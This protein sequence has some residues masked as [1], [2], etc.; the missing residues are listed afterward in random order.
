LK[1]QDIEVFTKEL[2]PGKGVIPP[3][4]I[5]LKIGKE[6]GIHEELKKLKDEKEK[7]NYL[8]ELNE[9]SEV[10]LFYTAGEVVDEKT[11][12]I[13]IKEKDLKTVFEHFFYENYEKD[14]RNVY[15]IRSKPINFGNEVNP[16]TMKY[17]DH[18]L[19]IENTKAGKTHLLMKVCLWYGRG[20]ASRLLGYSTS[21]KTFEGDLNN[22]FR[23]I[24][25][26]EIN[27]RGYPEEFFDYLPNIL[28]NGFER[29]GKGKQTLV[30]KTSSPFV[31]STNVGRKVEDPKELLVLFADFL[32]KFSESPQRIGSRIALTLFGNDFKEVRLKKDS[33]YRLTKKDIEINKYIVQAIYN[34]LSKIA[35]KIFEEKKIQDFLED[36]S[37]DIRKVFKNQIDAYLGNQPVKDYWL[38]VTEAYRHING[39]ALKQAI[40]DYYLENKEDLLS[41]TYDL[42]EIIELAKEHKIKIW[43]LN[44]ESFRKIVEANISNADYLLSVFKQIPKDYV[45]VLVALVARWSI[46]NKEVIEKGYQ[47]PLVQIG[48]YFEK[49]TGELRIGRYTNFARLEQAI[50]ANLEKVNSITRMFGFVLLKISENI[51]VSFIDKGS[52][53]L[54]FA[55]ALYQ[56]CTFCTSC[57]SCT[58]S[59]TKS[60]QSTKSTESTEMVYGYL[61]KEDKKYDKYELTYYEKLE[62]DLIEVVKNPPIGRLIY[63]FEAISFLSQ[64]GY[65]EEDIRKV[66]ENSLRNGILIMNPDGSLDINF[67]KLQGGFA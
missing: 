61:S 12:E 34:K 32:S 23:P 8:K 63:D 13:I 58:D 51:F 62:K 37:E 66:I 31:F 54:Q 53:I 41:E 14:E 1:K 42:D 40:L 27:R 64:R 49:L 5:I 46:E 10:P 22:Q 19:A 20:T 67:S 4:G 18:A 55:M 6:L 7:W 48:S 28:E 21:D 24:A 2:I 59:S 30:V 15:L 38:G 45:K 16:E 35:K 11:L 33:V 44:M 29:I 17:Q 43:S 36:D 65:K 25:C 57:T 9:K 47:I 39:M 52:N 56:T 26:D 50:P 3:E 60:T